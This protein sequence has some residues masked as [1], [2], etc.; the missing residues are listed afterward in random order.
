MERSVDGSIFIEP[1][2]RLPA[3]ESGKENRCTA[4]AATTSGWMMYLF[5]SARRHRWC[6]WPPNVH[7]VPIP[8]RQDDCH[9]S[10][11]ISTETGRDNGQDAVPRTI[12]TFRRGFEKKKF[13]AKPLVCA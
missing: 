7:H 3:G 13:Q 6:A 12:Q 5:S 10:G 8:T 11:E 1:S 2:V 9:R 4:C